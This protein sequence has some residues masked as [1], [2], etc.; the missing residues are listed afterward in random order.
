VFDIHS[1]ELVDLNFDFEKKLQSIR[2]IYDLG[3]T[4]KGRGA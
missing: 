1:G 3:T 2:E 4:N